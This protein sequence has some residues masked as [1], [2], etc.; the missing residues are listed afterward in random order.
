[1]KSRR[2]GN[3]LGPIMR[4]IAET[5]HGGFLAFTPGLSRKEPFSIFYFIFP[6]STPSTTRATAPQLPTRRLPVHP[7]ASPGPGIRGFADLL[8]R[9]TAASQTTASPSDIPFAESENKT[10][11]GKHC[12]WCLCPGAHLH[13]RR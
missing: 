11:R 13:A 1:M 5:F 4:N 8:A 10:L 12:A 6:V 7:P 2:F 3:S 9:D